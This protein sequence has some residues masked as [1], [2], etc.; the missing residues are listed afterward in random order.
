VSAALP[1][2]EA[3][4]APDTAPASRWRFNRAMSLGG[5]FAVGANIQR[6][7]DAAFKSPFD[8]WHTPMLGLID[9]LADGTPKRLYDPALLDE[10]TPNGPTEVLNTRYGIEFAYSFVKA[11][12]GL[13]PEDWQGAPLDRFRRVTDRNW[14]FLSD[15]DVVGNRIL[16]VRLAIDPDRSPALVPHVRDL[17]RLQDVLRAMYRHA[18]FRIALLNY[19][20]LE[21]E[22]A[23]W[24]G[25]R[26]SYCFFASVDHVRQADREG[27]PEAWDAA[28]GVMS[29]RFEPALAYAGSRAD[30]R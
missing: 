2:A 4:L 20:H 7:F 22:A 8:R 10:A 9:L 29:A 17:L 26:L 12:G 16:F 23:N 15:V 6:C 18:D 21:I 13:L 30:A 27:L 3:S 25:T 14:A 1:V 24:T 19:P 5:S 11:E 28:F